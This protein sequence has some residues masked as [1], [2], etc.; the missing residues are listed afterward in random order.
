MKEFISGIAVGAAN[1]IPGVSGGTMLVILGQFDKLMQSISDFF[2]I[3]TSMKD[4][5]KIVKYVLSVLLGAAVGIILF[6]KILEYLFNNFEVQTLF[7]F[8]GLI[9][10][11]L[12]MLKKQELK[13][14]K[15][16]P[17]FFI[18]GVGLIGIITF[19]A[20]DKGESTITLADLL[21][22]SLN[23]NYILLL[24]ALGA[25]SGATMIFPGVS[26][27]MVLLVLGWY[28]LFKA[29][30]ANVTSFELKVLILLVFIAIGVMVGIILSAKITSKLLKDFKTNTMS[31]IFGLIIM[32]AIIIIP[33]SGYDLFSIITSVLTFALGA[34]II[35]FIEKKKT[36][37]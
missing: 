26:G 23:F 28:H 30:V 35:I 20:P 11:S 7:C 14:E 31:F 24:I 12:P 25:I 4:R 6:A 15:I 17:L 27:S 32:S 3:E 1:I 16:N 13:N 21:A 22:K 9:L 2:K 29:Y 8:I 33:T 19:L 34:A 18:L 37:N 36:A 5:I 10:F